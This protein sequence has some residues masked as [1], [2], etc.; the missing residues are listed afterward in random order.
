MKTTKPNGDLKFHLKAL[1]NVLPVKPKQEFES[2]LR[3]K[4]LRNASAFG[5]FLKITKS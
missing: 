4:Y 1:G 3:Q 2:D 5:V